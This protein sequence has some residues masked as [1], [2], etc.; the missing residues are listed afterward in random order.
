MAQRH[1]GANIESCW[2]LRH[3]LH[4]P[5]NQTCMGCNTTRT[6]TR[7]KRER[8]REREREEVD[9]RRTRAMN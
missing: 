1:I 2:V 6:E 9:G 3:K 5:G 4:R 8:E 7:A